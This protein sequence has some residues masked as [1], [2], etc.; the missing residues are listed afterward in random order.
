MRKA[1]ALMSEGTIN[2][3][4][5]VTHIG[6]LN[7]VIPTTKNLPDIPGGKKL[8]YT[9]LDLELTAI[10]DFAEKGRTDPFFAAL[11]EI[12][13]RHD[14]IWSVEAETYLLAHGP[15]AQDA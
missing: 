1:L 11:A 14:G 6:G 12:T 4:A 13:D 2:P 7:A 15:A 8:M 3:A 10:D 9:H 5:L